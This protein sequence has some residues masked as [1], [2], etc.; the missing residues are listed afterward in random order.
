MPARSLV[1]RAPGLV[2]RAGL[3][4]AAALTV[5]AGRRPDDQDLLRRVNAEVNRSIRYEAEPPGQDV[6]RFGPR[7]GD[8]EDYAETKRIR[9]IAA[10]WPRR[11]L[12]VQSVSLRS[13]ECHAVLVAAD[14]QGRRWVLDNRTSGVETV[15][16]TG[17]RYSWD[18]CDG[19]DRGR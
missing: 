11:A 4:A 1:R 9:L 7:R 6:V 3:I 14:A 19:R 15:E 8:C 18:N 5:G 13:G 17:R 12:R 10:G 2:L 16:Q